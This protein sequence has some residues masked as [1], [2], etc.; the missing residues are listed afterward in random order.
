MYCSEFE[1]H[2]KL[3]LHFRPPLNTWDDWGSAAWGKSV[4]RLPIQKTVSK[5]GL[6]SVWCNRY[7]VL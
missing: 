4:Y 5:M 1:Q 6:H 2:A 7:A 3:L